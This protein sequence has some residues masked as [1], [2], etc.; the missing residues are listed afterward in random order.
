MC[1]NVIALLLVVDEENVPT[2]GS[3][4]LALSFS[5]PNLSMHARIGGAV[6]SVTTT[7]T[8]AVI[9]WRVLHANQIKG[10]HAEV[11]FTLQN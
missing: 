2:N 3:L 7:M 10:E 9:W 6:I 1:E 4:E 5:H 8:S 11:T